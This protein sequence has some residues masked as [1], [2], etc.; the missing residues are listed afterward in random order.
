M[1]YVGCWV[2]EAVP[3]NLILAVAPPNVQS[4]SAAAVPFTVAE[5]ASDSERE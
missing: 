5:L 4:S 3:E 1:G 2:P